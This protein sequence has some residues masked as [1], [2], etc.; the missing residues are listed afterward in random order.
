MNGCVQDFVEMCRQDLSGCCVS[1]LI[2]S[3]AEDC[4]LFLVFAGILPL[5]VESTKRSPYS[6]EWS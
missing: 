6:I 5:Q 3:C 1:E 4:A 2:V